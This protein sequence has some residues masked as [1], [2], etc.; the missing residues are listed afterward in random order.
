M[1]RALV[2]ANSSQTLSI[3]ALTALVIWRQCAFHSDSYRWQSLL[4]R[5]STMMVVTCVL[6]L[7]ACSLWPVRHSTLDW[8]SADHAGTMAPA[9]TGWGTHDHVCVP[10]PVSAP[11]Y[12]CQYHRYTITH[13][14]TTHMV[15][16]KYQGETFIV[17]VRNIVHYYPFNHEYIGFLNNVSFLP[18][19]V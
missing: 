2:T 9:Q 8:G 14:L 15:S 10:V 6:D 3:L 17:A 11:Q 18:S 12:V 7:K 13:L 4:R 1:P 16:R 5:R 19:N